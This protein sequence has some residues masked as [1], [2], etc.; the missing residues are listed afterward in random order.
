MRAQASGCGSHGTPKAAATH[1]LVI[2]SCVGPMPPVVNTWSNLARTS[3]TVAM[4]VS[5]TSGITRTSRTGMPISPSR[6]ARNWML[7]SCVRPDS[8]SLPITSRQA[9][10][11]L[12]VPVVVTGRPPSQEVPQQRDE[13][14]VGGRHWIF[15]E[16]LG[17]HPGERLALAR[18][19]PASPAAAQIERH[20]QV[21]PLV[22]VRGEGERR[23]TGAGD[24]DAQL[25]P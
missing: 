4:M 20:Q 25:L 23:E 11:L 7:K 18:L 13:R 10:G 21:K 8:T 1:S 16:L 5:A 15:G 9:V 2:S 22:G 6:F 14:L 24:V 19:R 3:L 12:A 17:S